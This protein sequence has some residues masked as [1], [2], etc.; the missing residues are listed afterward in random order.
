LVREDRTT[1]VHHLFAQSPHELAGEEFLRGL[2]EGRY[3]GYFKFAFVRNPW[4]RLV[5]CWSQKAIREG[6]IARRLSRRGTQDFRAFAEMVCATP[7]ER[8][9]PHFRSQH[10]GLLSENGER[11][12]DFL[13]RFETLEEDF[14]LVASKIGVETELPH[15]TPSGQTH[16]YRDLYDEELAERVGRRFRRDV[17]LF[18]Y[19]F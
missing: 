12:P 18:G 15:L 8:A 9:N 10:V 11:L 19:S 2:A 4:D 3:D 1:S 14:A 6:P 13:G 5:S 17:E 16:P 7:D